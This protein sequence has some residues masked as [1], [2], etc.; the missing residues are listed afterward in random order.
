M[1]CSRLKDYLDAEGVKYT[2]ILHSVAFTMQE[3]AS[4]THIPGR[5]IAKTVIVFADD[6][7]VMAVVPASRHVNLMQLKAVLGASTVMLAPEDDFRAAFPDC[8]VG[9]MPPFGHLYRMPV[10]VD[11]TLPGSEI[12]FN[13]GT[14]R[15]LIRMAWS[16]FERLAKP[17]ISSFSFLLAAAEA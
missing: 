7:L 3:V 2:S 6:H 9:A 13:A 8:E 4:L 5:E 17:V 10:F 1:R 16:D 15:E 11:A 12:I 14:H